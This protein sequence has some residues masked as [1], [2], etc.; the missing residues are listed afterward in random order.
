MKTVIADLQ[1]FKD[2]LKLVRRIYQH[3]QC[4]ALL[5]SFIRFEMGRFFASDIDVKTFLEE[6]NEQ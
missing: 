2:L 3:E 6:S 5:R 1:I 4:P